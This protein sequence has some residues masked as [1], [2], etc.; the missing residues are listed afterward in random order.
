MGRFMSPGWSA[1]ADHVPYARM[2]NPQSLN[3]CAYVGNNPLSRRDGDGHMPC[4]GSANITIDVNANGTSSMSQTPDC[5]DDSSNWILLS[6]LF[7]FGVGHHYIP[8]S[9]S[10]QFNSQTQKLANNITSG[11]LADKTRNYY[12]ALHRAYNDRVR[13]I[14]QQYLRDTGKSKKELSTSDIKAIIQKTKDAGGDIEKF[15][16]RLNADENPALRNMDEALGE[17]SKAAGEDAV[18]AIEETVEECESG[19]PCVPPL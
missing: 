19:A 1:S 15:N 16:D 9:I 7:G 13:T 11:P 3:L 2:D 12:D 18:D 8:Q 5:P 4:G 14:I 10:N 17:A 6:G